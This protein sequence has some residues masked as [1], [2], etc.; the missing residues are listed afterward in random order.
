[1]L[2]AAQPTWG[3]DAGAAATIHRLLLSLAQAGTAVLVVSQDLDEL[4]TIA[5]RIAV[6]ANGRLTPATPVEQLT[7]H[8]IGLRMGGRVP[9]AAGA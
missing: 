2:I 3:V 8:E 5:H 6:I 1:V 7:A 4:F 9:E